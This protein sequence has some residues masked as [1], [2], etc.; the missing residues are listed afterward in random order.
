MT[1]KQHQDWIDEVDYLADYFDR[2]IS[3]RGADYVD[4]PASLDRDLRH[5]R[6]DI[7]RMIRALSDGN[8]DV[9]SLVRLM[10]RFESWSGLL[11]ALTARMTSAFAEA[12]EKE[13]HRRAT[14]EAWEQHLK[15]M[16]ESRRQQEE[17]RAKYLRAGEGIT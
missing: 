8:A 7:T 9:Y 11:D 14:P 3:R 13:K 17:D 16:E 6:L 5:L 1:E 12:R 2:H 15:H 10:R 4:D